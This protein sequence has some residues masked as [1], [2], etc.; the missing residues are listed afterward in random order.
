M[1]T[2]LG[3]LPIVGLV[4]K[5]TY[6]AGIVWSLLIRATAEGF[7]RPNPGMPWTDIG[8]AIMYAFVFL[9]LLRL[10]AEAGRS[11]GGTRPYSLD[12]A[13]ERRIPRWRDIAEIRR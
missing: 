5:L 8:T 10:D 6:L 1:E 9:I 7:G 2:A 11:Q 13:V 12:A 4:R 3:L